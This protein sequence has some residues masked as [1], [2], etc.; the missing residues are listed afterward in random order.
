MTTSATILTVFQADNDRSITG[1]SQA[2]ISGS[3]KKNGNWLLKMTKLTYFTTSPQ[4]LITHFYLL[5]V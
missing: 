2:H 5:I 1:F 4:A 3:F